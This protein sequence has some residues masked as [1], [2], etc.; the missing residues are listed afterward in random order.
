MQQF[1]KSVLTYYIFLGSPSAPHNLTVHHLS[2]TALILNWATPADLGGRQEVMYNVECRQK[3]GESHTP[4]VLCD[5]T[6]VITPWST[7]LTETVAN[8][9][10][11]QPHVS[12]QVSVRAYNR[13]SQ[14]LSTS[15]S[16]QSI[17]ICR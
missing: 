2:D 6:M 11:L 8:I 1:K 10:G 5:N 4:W 12:Y 16:A 14:K 7:G 13:I 9:T 17:T 3:T 15:G